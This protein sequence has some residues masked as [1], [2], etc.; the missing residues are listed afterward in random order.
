M[1]ADRAHVQRIKQRLSLI[2]PVPPQVFIARPKRPRRPY[3]KPPSL[4]PSAPLSGSVA[5]Q[6]RAP[7]QTK[8]LVVELERISPT[9]R[10]DSNA[11]IQSTYLYEG[12]TKR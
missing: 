8:A 9:R 3:L 7:R 6:P 4:P 11:R 1:N 10:R 12:N 5:L 2:L